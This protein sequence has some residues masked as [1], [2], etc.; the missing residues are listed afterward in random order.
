MTLG[1]PY[2]LRDD[3]L[4][5]TLCGPLVT[6]LRHTHNQAVEQGGAAGLAAFNE[7]LG[8]FG[9]QLRESSCPLAPLVAPF[10]EQLLTLRQ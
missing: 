10:I 8:R 5:E 2:S 1:G 9:E 3:P 7:V 6:L 4:W